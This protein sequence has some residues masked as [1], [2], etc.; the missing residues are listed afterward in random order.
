M[1]FAWLSD[2]MSP[3]ARWDLRFLGWRMRES[4]ELADDK[5]D[6]DH[7]AKCPILLDWRAET[8]R[9]DWSESV[10]HKWVLAI[11]VDESDD[12]AKLLALGLGEVLPTNT[13]PVELAERTMRIAEYA[14][15]VSR[16]RTAGPVTLDLFHRDGR[17]D[18]QWLGF[19]PREFA[20]LWRLA[21]DPGQRVTRRELLSDVWRL[22]HDPQTN[23]VEVHV[24]RLRAKLAISNAGWLVV[25][26]PSGGYRLGED[27]G[28]SFFAYRNDRRQS[29]DSRSA[30]GNG[31]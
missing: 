13:G 14:H 3:P 31:K 21:E 29:M 4:A 26:D 28:K 24:S 27:G 25:T 15:S 16:Y 8:R 10:D 22:D 20:L 19:H 30:L 7:S 1:Q 5:D 17:I 6:V 23:S 12:R 11:G 9:Q 18:D 2:S